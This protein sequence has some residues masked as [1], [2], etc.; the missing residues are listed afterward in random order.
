M[1]SDLT[2][3]VGREWLPAPFV[4]TSFLLA[5]TMDIWNFRRRQKSQLWKANVSHDGHPSFLFLPNSAGSW[6]CVGERRDQCVILNLFLFR[7]VILDFSF[8]LFAIRVMYS[9]WLLLMFFC[10]YIDM[11]IYH[12]SESIT[13]PKL[14]KELILTSLGHI[15]CAKLE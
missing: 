1:R 11:L 3:E 6:S 14:A 13:T 8:E 10:S 5:K 15:E 7:Q 9:M 2:Y 12:R 4:L